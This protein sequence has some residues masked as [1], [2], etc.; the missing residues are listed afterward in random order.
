[1]RTQLFWRRAEF[2]YGRKGRLHMHKTE[3]YRRIGE[4]MNVYADLPKILWLSVVKESKQAFAERRNLCIE[5]LMQDEESA[6]RERHISW[7]RTAKAFD[8]IC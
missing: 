6:G 1:M 2:F 7:V 8:E 4:M 3:S 5:A